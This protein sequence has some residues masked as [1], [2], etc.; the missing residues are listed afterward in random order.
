[1]RL[2][3]ALIVAIGL[4]IMALAC[5]SESTPLPTLPPLTSSEVQQIASDAIQGIE[6]PDAITAEQVEQ[7]VADALS[8]APQDL[9]AEVQEIIAEAL[10]NVSMPDALTVEE[11]QVLVAQ[12]MANTLPDEVPQTERSVLPVGPP[13]LDQEGM[14]GILFEGS[15]DCGE[16]VEPPQGAGRGKLAA[17]IIGI[18]AWVN[19]EPLCLSDL[20]GNVVLVDFWTYTC[21]NC[22]RT[23]PYLRQWHARYADDGLVILGIHTPEFE[24]EEKRDNVQKASV[25]DA[26]VWPVALDNDYRTWRAYNNRYWPAKYLIDKD[27]IIRYT[28]FGEGAYAETEDEIKKLLEEAGADFSLFDY[29]SPKDQQ[30]DPSF[31]RGREI[32]RELYGGYG[33]GCYT[34]YLADI[35]VFCESRDMIH[36]YRDPGEYEDHLIYLEGPWLGTEESLRY[37][38]DTDHGDYSDYMLVKFSARTANVVLTPEEGGEPFKVLVTVDGQPLTEAN[39]GQDVVIEDDGRSFLV[40]DEPRLY[41]IVEAP[42]YGTYELKMSSNSPHFAIFAFTFGVYASGI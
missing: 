27:G 31:S 28:H 24:F 38:P 41:S 3:I 25:D 40:V 35:D 11:V 26:I 15:P 9:T 5:G 19:S 32:T 21:V 12:A 33:R 39:K 2:R 16:P 20:R 8:D 7:I 13:P 29:E 22:I 1:M 14:V 37:A 10:A 30:L 42:S 23:F 34:R 18:E 17:E 36:E 6:T 4:L